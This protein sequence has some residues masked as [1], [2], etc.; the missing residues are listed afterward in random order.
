STPIH[1]RL[2]KEW[3]NYAAEYSGM[4]LNRSE[5]NANDVTYCLEFHPD[6]P[7]P[8]VV[9]EDPDAM[10]VEEL[11]AQLLKTARQESLRKRMREI[12][13]LEER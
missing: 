5:D 6:T 7:E 2:Q 10:S 11:D 1:N 8:D 9:M 13:N 12:I 3:R 4:A